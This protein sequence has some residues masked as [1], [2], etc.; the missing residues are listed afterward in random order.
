[1]RLILPARNAAPLRPIHP[2]LRSFADD[3]KDTAVRLLAYIG[4]LALIAIVVVSLANPFADG[5]VEAA[6]QPAAHPAWSLAPRSHPAFAVSQIDLP[7]STE[8]YE[9]LR[10]PAGGRKDVLRWAAADGPAVA[11]LEIYRPGGELAWSGPPA[12]DIAARI[13]P[14]GT[15]EIES[16]GVIDSKFGPLTLLRLPGRQGRGCLGF[17]KSIDEPSLRLSGWTCQGDTQPAQRAAI[18]CMVS[19]LVLLSAGNDPKLAELFARAELR[20]E[21][22]SASAAPPLSADWVG[23]HQ[24]PRLRGSL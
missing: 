16:A 24:N 21:P 12:A 17:V 22:C 23:G 11:E 13:D 3:C 15:R 1:M 6:M 7:N 8:T 14:D 20:R 2:E 5:A 18:G 10:N 19:R 9:I 4:A